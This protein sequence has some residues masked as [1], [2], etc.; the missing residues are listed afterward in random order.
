MRKAILL[1]G[2]M[3]SIS[4]A[5]WKKPA[6]AITIDY[7]QL[8]APTEIRTSSI[9]SEQLGIEHHVIKIN[10]ADLG[11]GDLVNKKNVNI[12][13]S[14][15]WWPFRNQLLVTFALMKAVTLNVKEIMV[16]SVNSDGFHRDGT[17]KF[18]HLL[19]QVSLYQ[20]GEINVTAP[21]IH[22]N[23]IELIKESAVPKSL[24]LWAY[25]C[26][27]STVACGKCRGCLKYSQVINSLFYGA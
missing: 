27:K 21:C 1:S 4:L 19:N 26:H 5:F 22:L 24:L 20:E 15:E 3:D 14:P 11:V 9:V 12:S 18:Y 10:C 13:P 23:T 17:S 8:P 16:A 25:S 2:G 6:V 7:G